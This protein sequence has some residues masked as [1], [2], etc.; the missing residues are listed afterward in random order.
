VRSR[1]I[2]FQS[3]ALTFLLSFFSSMGWPGPLPEGFVYLEEMIPNIKVDLRYYTSNNFVGE[4]IEGYLGPRCILTKEAAEALKKVQEDLKPFGLGLKIYDAYRPQQAVNHFVRWA[5]DLQD[6]RMKSKFYPEVEKRD[7][8][9][10]GYIAEKSS[11][12][13]G[14]TIDLTIVS[15]TSEGIARELYMGTGF[16]FFSLKSRP[17]DLS[18]APAQRAQRLLLQTLMKN[19]GF[20]P[21]PQEWWHFTLK[22]EPYPD[23]YFDFPVR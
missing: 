19:H 8:F 4:R 13:R 15:M 10:R 5:K 2:L 12:T 3:L 23:T 18:M 7:L 1:R 6:T 21:Y 17:D 22:N 9:S 11:H 14:S 20:N 16:D